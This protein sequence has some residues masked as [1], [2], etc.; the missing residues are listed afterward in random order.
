[1]N[2]A[3]GRCVRHA[4]DWGAVLL[5]DSRFADAGR[6]KNL[7]AWLRHEIRQPAPF[8]DV[9]AHL[10]SFIHEHHGR[11]PAPKASEKAPTAFGLSSSSRVSA[12]PV[13]KT[14]D[15]FDSLKKLQR[16]VRK[17]P[18]SVQDPRVSAFLAKRTKVEQPPKATL[19]REAPL[20]TEARSVKKK[21]LPV[22]KRAPVAFPATSSST[23]VK[24]AVAAFPS[25]KAGERRRATHE[26]VRAA[27]RS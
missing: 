17:A 15:A 8:R 26:G 6:R 5:A 23:R 11:K 22:V 16:Q 27:A 4:K 9:A 13:V 7:P 21:A 10:R 12:K 20:E 19:R 18:A 3:V 24:D 2:Q 1:M 14:E 25:R